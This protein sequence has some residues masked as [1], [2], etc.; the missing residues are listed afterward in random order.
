MTVERTFAKNSN[1]HN[2]NGCK[3]ENPY[4]ISKKDYR[5]GK[6]RMPKHPRPEKKKQSPS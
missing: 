4:H 5:D 3:T 1:G 6:R 2:G